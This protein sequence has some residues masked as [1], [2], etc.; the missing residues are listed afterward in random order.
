MTAV[1]APENI[2]FNNGDGNGKQ[3][4]DLAFVA[5]KTYTHIY[6]VVGNTNGTEAGADDLVF[7]K[8]WEV[9]LNP[10]TEQADGT[11]TLT[12]EVELT[13]TTSIQFKA[14][15]G[16]DWEITYGKS[17]GGNQDYNDV[18]PG[19]YTV[20]FTL[21]LAAEGDKMTATFEPVVETQ[22][23]TVSFT[24]P[25]WDAVY[26]YAWTGD[27]PVAAWPGTQL[28]KT[29][30]VYTYTVTAT[31]APEKI[32]FNNGDGNGKQTPDLA[33]VADKTYTHIYTVVGNTNGNEA[34]ADD[35]VFGK[36]W[37]VT[38][39][40]MTEQ[41]D[42]TWTL[43][44]EVE[45]TETTSI[46]FKAAYGNDWEITYGKS[47]GGN[48]DYNDVAPGKYTVTFTLNLAAEGDKM[49]A[50]FEP[51]KQ[52]Y[53]VTFVNTGN[54]AEVAAYAW[55]GEGESATPVAAWPGTKLEKTD[56]KEIDGVTYDVYTYT[57]NAVAA[58]EKILFNDNKAEGA[59]QTD[60]LAFVAGQEY[61]YEVPPTYTVTFV[62]TGKWDEVAAYAW[63]TEGETTTNFSAAWPGDKLMKTTTK[64]IDGITYD[65]Y[66][67]SYTGK[68]AP[69]RIIFNDNK[70]EEAQQTEDYEFVDG[71]EYSTALPTFT[72][73]FVNTG[74]WAE[75]AAYAWTDGN[76]TTEFAGAWP[77]KAL[78][79][80][81]KKVDG[82]D[83][84]TYTVQAAVAPEKIIF[85]DN[86]AEGATQ[87]DDEAFVDG[88]Q[89]SYIVP[90]TITATFVN[91]GD[92]TKVYAWAWTTE[93]EG[94]AA[95][96]T[97]YSGE[98]PGVELTEKAAE[99]IDGHD[100]YVFTYT[101]KTL[102][103]SI[104][105][106]N[107][108]GTQ[109]KDFTLVN[110]QQYEYSIEVGV[111]FVNTG[112]WAEVYAYT[113]TGENQQAG[114]W[115]GTKL[116]KSGTENID[117]T[118]YDVY[119]W[120]YTGIAAP[121]N[122]IFNDG[123][124]TQTE[125]LEFV[126]GKEYSYEAKQTLTIYFI[127]ERVAS[128]KALI[129]WNDGVYMYVWDNDDQRLNGDFP[130]EQMTKEDR[131]I[132]I[133]GKNYDLYKWTKTIALD[134]NHPK[135]IIFSNGTGGM[136]NQTGNMEF[137]NNMYY[138]FTGNP[139]EDVE[140]NGRTCYVFDDNITEFTAHNATEARPVIYNREFTVDMPS[141]FCLPFALDEDNIA[142]IAEG[143]TVFELKS[144]D[145]KKLIYNS[146][147]QTEANKP[148]Y[149]LPKKQYAFTQVQVTSTTVT[150]YFDVK[151]V[152]KTPETMPVTAQ[153]G[154]DITAEMIGSYS[155]F[156]LTSDDEWTYFAYS[157]ND[158]TDDAGG[159]QAGEFAKASVLHV[160]P[161]RAYIRIKTA[162]ML[163][164]GMTDAKF[165]VQFG[166][167]AT[168]I[169]TVNTADGPGS[170]KVYTIDGRIA[171]T[172]GTV[173]GLARGLYIINGKKYVVK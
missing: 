150:P 143:G 67:W 77:G 158:V 166:D 45:L 140:W 27:T 15:Y 149:F 44:K 56:T 31:A 47:D 171:G 155:T 112:K 29:G 130:G 152:E 76:P 94:E 102:P 69:A 89:Y 43:T 17:D 37:E 80:T 114:A 107:G 46:Q 161:F 131:Q 134:A 68:V 147:K 30:D 42:G 34:G 78:E 141:T 111:T 81:G 172:D 18:A 136:D 70:A 123:N 91:T 154:N 71:K 151:V 90:Q 9:T 124:G 49:T 99:Q 87:T 173:N 16:N 146:V 72:V 11:W 2:I 104:L 59:T 125:D 7:G 148:Y 40:P 57:V 110:G 169:R 129:E 26:A 38:L 119:S 33:F 3:T 13:E 39:N 122:I 4:P 144:F 8:A 75:V 28:T 167:D 23:F 61:S 108:E 98:W 113:W 109:T 55:S 74:D 116:T 170:G 118:D 95:V 22:D 66:S 156:D 92:W 51:V 50:T 53:T 115:P 63:T 83:V 41:A 60:D 62:N 20:T 120:S 101:G 138:T 10:M 121:A 73:T 133:N 164:K 82:H 64:T 54:W 1:T 157:Q 159:V 24:D 6:T 163:A 79:T 137:V 32:I 25:G 65:V 117:G 12:K 100:V 168:A 145:G 19:K 160:K 132:S 106:N 14:A 58:P 139:Y 162:E 88:K 86:K 165:S 135:G 5:D 85:N 105:F 48:Q 153:T 127:N 52:D 84:Y 103:A 126:D 97:N 93:G 21:N 35:L 128:E 36:A 96:T 142:A